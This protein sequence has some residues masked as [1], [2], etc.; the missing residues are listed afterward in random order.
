MQIIAKCDDLDELYEYYMYNYY[1]IIK[2]Q[3]KFNFFSIIFVVRSKGRVG[4]QYGLSIFLLGGLVC[5]ITSLTISIVCVR[6]VLNRRRNKETSKPIPA[7]LPVRTD[8][9]LPAENGY[10]VARVYPETRSSTFLSC[11]QFGDVVYHHNFVF[12]NSP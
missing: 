6:L 12:K 3:L 1:Y 9:L 11:T 4:N 10:V 8:S 5:G 7:N 2:Y